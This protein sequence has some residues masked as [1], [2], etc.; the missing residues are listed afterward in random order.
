L[1]FLTY[2]DSIINYP[3]I[4][5]DSRVYGI[6]PE[7]AAHNILEKKSAWLKFI[8]LIEEIRL[9]YNK[10]VL[11]ALC[12]PDIDRLRFSF[13]HELNNIHDTP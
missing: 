5:V 3:L 6:K 4:D 11:D 10:R 13:K 7:E 12:I 8:T 9:S 2:N 1:D